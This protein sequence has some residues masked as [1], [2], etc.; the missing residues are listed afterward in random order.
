MIRR[1]ESLRDGR[2]ISVWDLKG[3]IDAQVGNELI[4]F[5]W[6]GDPC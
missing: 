1:V 2:M 5:A 3:E 4:P 6:R